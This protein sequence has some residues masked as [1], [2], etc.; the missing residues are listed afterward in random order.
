[1]SDGFDFDDRAFLAGLDRLVDRVSGNA[2]RVVIDVADD[3]V[4]EMKR[5]APDRTGRLRRGISKKFGKDFRGPYADLMVEPFYASF[6][7]WGTSREAAQP[8]VRPSLELAPAA[9]RRRAP[10][11]L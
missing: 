6:K 7:E 1:M 10:N 5:R 9:L 3:L 4:E 8:F 2:G 11:L